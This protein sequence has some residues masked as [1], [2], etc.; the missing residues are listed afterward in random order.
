MEAGLIDFLFL[1]DEISI[2][3]SERGIKVVTV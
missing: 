2:L 3:Q 1:V